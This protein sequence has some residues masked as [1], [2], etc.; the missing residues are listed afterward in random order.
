MPNVEHVLQTYRLLARWGR[1]RYK[2]TVSL[3]R[4][5]TFYTPRG[6]YKDGVPLGRCGRLGI[7]LGRPGGTGGVCWGVPVGRVRCVEASQ[8]DGLVCLG[9]PVGRVGMLGV[10]VGRVARW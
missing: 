3:V 6:G 9:V 7:P 8:W 1:A 2:Y 10:P 5:V 4:V